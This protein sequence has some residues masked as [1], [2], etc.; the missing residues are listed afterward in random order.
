MNPKNIGR[1]SDPSLRSGFHTKFRL[2]WAAWFL[3][4]I[5]ALVVLAGFTA[6]YSFET[7][8]REHPYAPPTHV[9]FID[10]AGKF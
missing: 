3:L 5:H 10:C 2:T 9:H 1:R 7:Q 8:E 6:P 4:A